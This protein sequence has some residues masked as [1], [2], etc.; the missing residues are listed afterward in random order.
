MLVSGRVSNGTYLICFLFSGWSSACRFYPGSTS[1]TEKIQAPFVTSGQSRHQSCWSLSGTVDGWNPIPNHLGWCWN[2]INNGRKTTCPSTGAGFQPSTVS[3]QWWSE[4]RKFSGRLCVFFECQ[5]AAECRR[6]FGRKI[7]PRKT[8]ARGEGKCH[9]ASR[10]HKKNN[11]NYTTIKWWRYP[12]LQIVVLNSW[13]W[14]FKS[15]LL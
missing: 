5:S 7:A 13:E 10:C 12:K 8:N 4:T 1:E 14:Y 6:P 3:P 2:P 9:Y 11:C 15:I